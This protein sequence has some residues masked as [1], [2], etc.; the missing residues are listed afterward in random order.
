M[1]GVAIL[2]VFDYRKAQQ[3]EQVDDCWCYTVLI[4]ACDSHTLVA[5]I[6]EDLRVRKLFVNLCAGKCIE[7]CIGMYRH[8]Y[9][10]A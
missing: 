1:L 4:H 9:R 2:E 5:R 8:V 7:M 6:A 10:R 3:D